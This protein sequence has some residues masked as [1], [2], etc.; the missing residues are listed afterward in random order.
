MA[1]NKLDNTRLVK[2]TVFLYIRMFFV[3][4]VSFYTSRVVLQVLGVNDFGIYN[5]VAGFVS[6]FG[7][8]NATLSSSMQRFYN[9]EGTRRYHD[10]YVAGLTIHIA[11]ALFL[12]VLLETIGVWY[13]NSVMVITEGRLVAANIVFQ[14]TIISMLFVIL[15]IPYT[16]AIMADERM[17]YYALISII[18]V[19]LKLVAVLILPQLPY[20][21]LIAYSVLLLIVSILSFC[22]YFF[23]SKSKILVGKVTFH[24]LFHKGSSRALLKDI[25]GF[26]GWNLFGSFVF[27]VKVQGLNLLLN[28]F[29]GPVVNAARGISMQVNGGITGFSGNV[30]IAFRPQIVSSY[31]ESDIK[32]CLSLMFYESKICYC[33]ILL[34]IIP[35]II[36][37]DYILSLWLGSVIPDRANIFSILVLIDSLVCTLNTPMTQV[38]FATGKIRFYQICSSCVNLLL[39]P[40]SFVLLKL[41]YN[42]ES[43]FWMTIIFSIANNIGCF[44]AIRKLVSFSIWDYLRT[45]LIPCLSVTILISV[46]PFLV[47][48]KMTPGLNR[49][50]FV[51]LYQFMVGI[52]LILVIVFSKSERRA[53]FR[54]I[55]PKRYA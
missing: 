28:L 5:V 23:Y 42:P 7:F 36:D 24:D 30:A 15:Q 17:D 45:V 29:F 55:T 49:L 2:N 35:V 10:V 25:L 32:R 26:S 18:D 31:A 27:L 9:Y 34:L 19:I 46:V 12:F 52:P 13:V 37:I 39:L 20:D 41:G 47:W 40:I 33:L 14:A 50:L 53:F 51:C 8:F 38:A 21:S 4:I 43:V 1:L 48:S 3:L 54:I 22:C 6:M 16:G 44:Y 11:L